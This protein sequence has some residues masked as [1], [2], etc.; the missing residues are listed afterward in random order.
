MTKQF[1]TAQ[2]SH[3]HSLQTLNLLQQYDD[4]MESIDTLVDL[5]CGDGLDLEWWATRTTRGDNPRPLNINCTGVD[6]AEAMPMAQRYPNITYQRNNF[7]E[8]V[9]TVKTAN[10][11]KFDVLWCHDSFQYCFN[12][13]QTLS[14]WH[15]ITADGGMLAIQIQQTTNLRHNHSD[16]TQRSESYYHYTL[17]NLIHMLAITGWDCHT[18]YF[19]KDPTDPWIKAVVYKSSRG[20]QDPRT[21]TWYDLAEQKMLPQTAIESVMAHGYLRQEDLLLEWLDHSLH[22]YG[23]D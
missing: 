20:P 15:D 8:V 23:R 11:D 22:W 4:F 9:H 14:K 19:L 16:F 7:E 17:V 13:I 1:A 12:P 6:M 5:G 21:T 2:E 18:G 10:S 3:Q